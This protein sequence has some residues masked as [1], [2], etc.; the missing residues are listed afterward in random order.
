[1]DPSLRPTGLRHR[2]I[3]AL[4]LV[5]LLCFEGGCVHDW[6]PSTPDQIE[7][8]TSPQTVRVWLRPSAP[9][10]QPGQLWNELGPSGNGADILVVDEASVREGSLTGAGGY[11]LD[12]RRIARLEV[13]KLDG[14]ATAGV[15]VA[16]ILGGIGT[17]IGLFIVI[18][19][20]G[21]R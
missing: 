8:T 6:V 7:Q 20:P 15:V 19:K 3:L 17:A 18:V 13:R 10:W 14:G 12:V 1:M 2:G 5:G 4:V 11:T 16:S 21:I 9:T